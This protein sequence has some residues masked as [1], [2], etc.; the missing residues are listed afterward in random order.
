MKSLNFTV[1]KIVEVAL[2]TLTL[3]TVGKNL[4]IDFMMRF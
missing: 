4:A 2:F 1:M 3:V